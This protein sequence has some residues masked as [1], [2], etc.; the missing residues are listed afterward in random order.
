MQQIYSTGQVA[1]LIGIQ[2]HRIEYALTSGQLAEP[3]FR[4]LGKRVYTPNDVQRVADHFGILLGGDLKVVVAG[5]EE[6]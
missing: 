2:A 3:A 4:F 5:K 1:A 6:Q